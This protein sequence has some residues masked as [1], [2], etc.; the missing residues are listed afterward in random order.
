MKAGQL[1]RVITVQSFASVP[2]SWGTP[3][4]TWTN[5]ATLRAHV[6]QSSTDEFIRAFGASDETVTVFRTRYIAGVTTSHRVVHDGKVHNIK[7]I[8][9]IGRRKALELRTVSIGQIA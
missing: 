4:P 3:V 9:E 6:I 8:K 7:E 2:D 1:D 5:V